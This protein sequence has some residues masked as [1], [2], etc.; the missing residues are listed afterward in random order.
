[1]LG[2]YFVFFSFGFQSFLRSPIEQWCS[3]ISEGSLG[4][5]RDTQHAWLYESIACWIDDLI[6]ERAVLLELPTSCLGRKAKF[7]RVSCWLAVRMGGLI[8]CFALVDLIALDFTASRWISKM[9]LGM[10]WARGVRGGL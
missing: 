1:M 7:G 10:F 3:V 6:R 9:L 2:R 8:L 4:T 5:D